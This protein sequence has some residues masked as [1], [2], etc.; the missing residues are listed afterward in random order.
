[1]HETFSETFSQPSKELCGRTQKNK[2]IP[3]ISNLPTKKKERKYFYQII[4]NC[5][6]ITAVLLDHL[7]VYGWKL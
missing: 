3:L 2:G 1:M 6:P 7:I 4:L 5:F